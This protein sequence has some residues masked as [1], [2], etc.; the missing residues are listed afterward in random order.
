[1]AARLRTEEKNGPAGRMVDFFDRDPTAPVG[2]TRRDRIEPGEEMMS[3]PRSAGPTDSDQPL[4]ALEPRIVW[5]H[6]DGIRRVPRPSKQE[7]RIVRHVCN[8]ATSHDFE[9]LSDGPEGGL[10]NLV[11][12]VPASPGLE[13]APTVVLQAHLDM[14]CEKNADSPH[15]FDHDPIAVV[16][17]GDWVRAEGTTLG[18]DNGLGVAAAMAAAVDPELRHGPLELLFTLDEETGLH[19]AAALDP[20]LVTGRILVNLDTEEDG[21][22]YVGCAGA[23]GLQAF[24]RGRRFGHTG[25]ARRLVVRGLRG[26]HSGVE[27]HDNR[28]NANRI[29]ARLLAE[30]L[31][32]GVDFGLVSFDGGDKANAIP[33][34]CFVGLRLDPPD[35]AA[36]VQRIEQALPAIRDEL[37]AADP[38]LEV[39][40]EPVE[41][42]GDRVLE[43]RLRDAMVHLL[44]SA[45]HGVLAMSREVPGLVETSCN[46]AVVASHDDGVALTFSI[47]SSVTA[48]LGGT[49]RGLRSLCNLAAAEV[50]ADTGYPGWKPEPESPLV[51]RTAAVYEGLFGQPPEIKAVHAGLE[52]G[53]LAEKIPG[54]KAVSIGPDIRGA[55]SPTERASIPSTQRFYRFL[56]ALLADLAEAVP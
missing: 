16:V 3:T 36:L 25:E 15:D 6:F 9:V 27:I 20:D 38:G 40:L 47:R 34:E 44:A 28:G 37:G 21:A 10:G 18:A 22:V 24:L 5:S 13:N 14:V 39:R 52:C 33:R 46:L 30:A 17:E 26:G 4:A 8:W 11:I 41:T 29:A 53:I 45:P 43:P 7:E 51:R 1:M 23:A 50:H 49:L 32:S 42:L 31:D 35:L 12:R 19:G 48:A 54:L 55:H 2:Y 56:G